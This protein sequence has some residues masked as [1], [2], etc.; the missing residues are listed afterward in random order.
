MKTLIIKTFLIAILL[1][2]YFTIV[3]YAQSGK[4]N[5]ALIKQIDSMFKDDQF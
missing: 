3:S 1:L 4:Q 2:G 5:A